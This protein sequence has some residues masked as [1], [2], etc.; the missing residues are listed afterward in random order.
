ML[1]EGVNA[2]SSGWFGGGEQLGYGRAGRRVSTIH[3]KEKKRLTGATMLTTGH[4]HWSTAALTCDG[5]WL[6]CAG[7]G[8]GRGCW[9]MLTD[10]RMTGR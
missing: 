3:E 2:A 1:G 5:I 8:L 7:E 4:W 10:G 6:C 9:P